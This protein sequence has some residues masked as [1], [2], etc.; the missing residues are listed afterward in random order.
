[1]MESV[2]VHEVGHQWFY[3]MVGNDQLDEPWL[4]ESLTQFVTWEYYLDKYGPAGAAGFEGSLRGRWERVDNEPIPI[5][6]PVAAYEGS[7]YSAIVYGR[8]AFFFEALR[9]K[10]GEEAFDAFLNDYAISNAWGIGTGENMKDL[11]EKHCNCNLTKL[12]KEWVYP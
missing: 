8:G 11:A 4:D 1:M 10:M 7:A 5:G 2:M 9:E 12:Y 3:N 6:M